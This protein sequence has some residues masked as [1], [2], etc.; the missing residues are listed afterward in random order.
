[1]DGEFFVQRG[2][3]REEG[4]ATRR[5]YNDLPGI[6]GAGAFVETGHWGRDLESSGEV[7]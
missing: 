4:G 6:A 3:E 5:F 1:M 2:E 7:G